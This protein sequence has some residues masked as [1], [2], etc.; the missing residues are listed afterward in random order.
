VD[1]PMRA[2]AD[3]LRRGSN[4]DG[5]MK[6]VEMEDK[7]GERTSM[8]RGRNDPCFCASGLKFKKCHGKQR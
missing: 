2:M 3:L 7:G 8:K 6:V 4:A 5:V 1:K